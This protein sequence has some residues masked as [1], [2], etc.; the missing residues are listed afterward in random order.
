MTGRPVALITG[1]SRGLGRALAAGFAR[2]GYDVAVH[3]NTSEDGA[4]ETAALVER[5]GGR[6]FLVRADVRGS[7]EVDAMMK[8]VDA[9]FGGLDV[10]VNNAGLVR[11][12]TIARMSDEEWRDVVAANLDGT[13]YCTRAALPLM[14]KKRAGVVLSMSSFVAGRGTRGA[15]NYAAAKAGIEAFTK[16]LAQEEAANGI[17]ANAIVPGFHVT[18]INRDYWAKHEETIRAQHLLSTMPDRGELADFVVK[19]AGLS[20]V[21]GQVFAFESRIL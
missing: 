9:E 7:A 16:S 11:N 17:R 18:D 13:F 4:R 10:L 15:A 8:R 6:A 3:H 20:T 5:A 12:R 1:A 14:R 21:T 19:I 2:G